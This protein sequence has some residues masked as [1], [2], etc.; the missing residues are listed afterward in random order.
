MKLI[1]KHPFINLEF[2][3]YVM[4]I[5]NWQENSNGNLYKQGV[6]GSL[7]RIYLVVI[8]TAR[9]LSHIYGGQHCCLTTGNSLK[10]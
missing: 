4:E 3:Q 2:L 7:K 6:K 9:H 8:I 5:E 10:T 1:G